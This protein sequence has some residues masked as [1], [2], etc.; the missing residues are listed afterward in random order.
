MSETLQRPYRAKA[1]AT[2]LAIVGGT[3]GWHRLYLRGLADPLA[4]LHLI[5]TALGVVGVLRVRALGVDDRLSWGLLPLMGLMLSYAMA[6]A[7]RYGLTP[8]ERW[9]ARHN[10]GWPG[11]DTRWAPVLGAVFALLVGAGFFMATV[12]FTGQRLFELE[13][14]ASRAAAAASAPSSLR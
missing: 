3:L 4:W 14:E 12:A 7:I 13:M 6:T 5:P 1:V 10:P 11:R 2:W 9:D 8:D